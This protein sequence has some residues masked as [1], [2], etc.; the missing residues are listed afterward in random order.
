MLVF[1]ATGISANKLPTIV[2]NAAAG[3]ARDEA[4]GDATTDAGSSCWTIETHGLGHGWSESGGRQQWIGM[5]RRAPAGRG[6][7][8]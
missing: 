6:Q 2:A 3:R 1:D 5:Q 7:N 8:D 4:G